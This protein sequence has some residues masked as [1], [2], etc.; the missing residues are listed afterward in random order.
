MFRSASSLL[1]CCWVLTLRI[2]CLHVAAVVLCLRDGRHLVVSTGVDYLVWHGPDKYRSFRADRYDRSL[3]RADLKL[4]EQER[5]RELTRIFS[6][7]NCIFSPEWWRLSDPHRRM[8]WYLHRNPRV[9][10]AYPHLRTQSALLPWENEWFFAVCVRVQDTYLVMA[11]ALTSPSSEP[12]SMR[13]AWPS[14][15][16]Q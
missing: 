3:V 6:K 7:S 15:I 1:R 16:S 9:S 11:R 4:Q 10:R 14:K 2:A 8:C 13:M 5:E 12:S